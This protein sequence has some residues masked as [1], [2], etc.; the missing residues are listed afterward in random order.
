MAGG[1]PDDIRRPVSPD[2]HWVSVRR[3]V[4]VVSETTGGGCVVVV[5][6]VTLV[7]V[8]G[9]ELAQPTSMAVLA[10]SATPIAR[11]RRDVVYVIVM[12]L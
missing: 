11:P 7:V 8:T 3:V 6:S 5:C 12:L 2:R 9:G 4:V 10:T 1:V